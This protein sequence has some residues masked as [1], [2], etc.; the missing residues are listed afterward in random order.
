MDDET[1]PKRGRGR[2]PGSRNK[3]P[4]RQV[5]PGTTA[6]ADYRHADPDS[7]ISRQLGLIDW[8]QQA[9]R[10]EMKVGLSAAEG[11]RVSVSDVGMIE[12]LSNALVRA[13]DALKKSADVAEE[14]AARMS[15]EDLLEAALSKVEGQDLPT[16]NYAIKRLR[17]HRDR[18]APITAT[19]RS[20]LGEVTTPATDAI[21]SLGT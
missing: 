1:E 10:N 4:D 21:A 16:L 9:L 20:Q 13:L 17:A 6:L 19:D 7:L 18:L 14:M 5:P 3:A 11:K 12:K 2:P 8:A 15:P